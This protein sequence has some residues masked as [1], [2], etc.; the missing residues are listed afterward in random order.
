MSTFNLFVVVAAAAAAAESTWVIIRLTICLS[1]DEWG[2]D[3]GG[4]DV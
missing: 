1:R 4:D 2:G 3:G